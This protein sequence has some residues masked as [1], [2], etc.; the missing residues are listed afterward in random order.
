M[1]SETEP[2]GVTPE[3]RRDVAGVSASHGYADEKGSHHSTTEVIQEQEETFDDH[4]V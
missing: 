3:L 2:T 4:D 1:M